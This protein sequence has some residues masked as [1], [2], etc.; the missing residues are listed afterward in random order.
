MMG[1][2]EQMMLSP[3]SDILKERFDLLIRLGTAFEQSQ[4]NT[5]KD[6]YV[7]AM[8]LVLDSVGVTPTLEDMLRDA[9]TLN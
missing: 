4:D 3:P 9:Q 1:E 6:F 5:C 7:Q 8:S 2:L